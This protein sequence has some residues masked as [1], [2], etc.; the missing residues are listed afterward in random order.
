M[1]THSWYREAG[2][3]GSLTLE[4]LL[5]CFMFLGYFSDKIS[6]LPRAD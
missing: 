4:P 1:V 2:F 6:L 5:H 3:A